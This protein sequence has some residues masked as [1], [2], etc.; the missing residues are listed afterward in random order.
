MFLSKRKDQVAAW[1]SVQI[2]SLSRIRLQQGVVDIAARNAKRLC[3]LAHG[4]FLA[5]PCRHELAA[6]RDGVLLLRL[7][8]S[9]LAG[10]ALDDQD[11]LAAR[12]L[13]VVIVCEFLQRAAVEFLEALRELTTECSAACAP[14]DSYELA[15]CRA[16]VV[17]RLVEDQRLTVIFD[18]C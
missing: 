12:L 18:L 15:Q 10:E 11:V 1:S 7:R 4:V 14:E 9:L 6:E 13:R 3:R 8:F 2:Q 5:E 16:Q 17:W